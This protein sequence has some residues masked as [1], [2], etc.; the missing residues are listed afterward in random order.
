MAISST[1]YQEALRAFP[2]GVT[3]VT[4]RNALGEPMGATVGAFM[5]L[6]LAPPLVLVSLGRESRTG[7]AIVGAGAFVVH[8]VNEATVP[9]ARRFATHADDKFKGVR[10]GLS[11]TGLPTLLDLETRLICSVHAQHSAGDHTI[12]VGHVDE[13]DIPPDPNPS[14]AWC[15]R[16]FCQ[17]IALPEKG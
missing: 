10:S 16:Q 3:I 11:R 6:S 8:F 15:A 7:A 1:E 9:L 14:V 12:F 2:Q 4:S 17:L 13:A 5:A